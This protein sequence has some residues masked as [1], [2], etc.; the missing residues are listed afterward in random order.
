MFGW[1]FLGLTSTKQRIKCHAQGHTTV[2]QVNLDWR[3]EKRNY[4]VFNS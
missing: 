1:V 3:Y 2:P 4:V